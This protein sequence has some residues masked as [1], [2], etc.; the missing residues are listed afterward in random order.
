MS[1]LEHIW[2]HSFGLR[3][4]HDSTSSRCGNKYRRSRNTAV[5]ASEV[6]GS[7]EHRRI[8]R[9]HRLSVLI[10]GARTKPDAQLTRKSKSNGP[11]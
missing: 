7:A 8:G 6:A 10:V 2:I 1:R 5:D 4:T 11:S 9:P 3:S